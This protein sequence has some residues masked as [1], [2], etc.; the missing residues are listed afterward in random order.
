MN[1]K[2]I[3]SI[4]L[5]TLIL[6]SC[7]NVG[8]GNTTPANT[9]IKTS[10]NKVTMQSASNNATAEDESTFV[11]SV[12]EVNDVLVLSPNKMVYID[13]QSGLRI[14]SGVDA[15]LSESAILDDTKL[16]DFVKQNLGKFVVVTDAKQQP[17]IPDNSYAID[18]D[19]DNHS[20]SW[21]S[22]VD[23]NTWKQYS[24]NV[25]KPSGSVEILQTGKLNVPFQKTRS[26]SFINSDILDNTK[27]ISLNYLTGGLYTNEDGE[28]V[29]GVVHQTYLA[30]TATPI[31]LEMATSGQD[32]ATKSIAENKI[33][34]PLYNSATVPSLY[35]FTGSTK[36]AQQ[37]I[38][39][40]THNIAVIGSNVPAHERSFWDNWGIALA[41]AFFGSVV[42]IIASRNI[43]KN[44]VKEYKAKFIVD[45]NRY[46][47]SVKTTLSAPKIITYNKNEIKTNEQ[48]NE[49][50]N[51]VTNKGT[52]KQISND[53]ISKEV[54]DLIYD[55]DKFN[56]ASFKLDADT[57]LLT[58][59]GAS[60]KE[61]RA[62]ALEERFNQ[63]N[64][65]YKYDCLKN[66]K[67][68]DS[69]RVFKI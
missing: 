17:Y 67:I 1:K 8:G 63:N 13:S 52:S 65:N 20:I 29:D 56:E 4:L 6:N 33:T 23:N 21:V 68:F 37:Y 2:L 62:S 40:N 24:F 69:F 22:F 41:G 11:R 36:N 64:K 46:E 32:N 35:Q 42:G 14:W 12:F 58:I 15:N 47:N 26:I 66:F 7:Y 39:E 5:S 54:Q 3:C 16:R 45:A 55:R 61:I 43:A 9:A 28:T 60:G 49:N 30:K 51:A 48:V 19:D 44:N 50:S 31:I 34:E 38:K 27:L 25:F 57:G 10:K 59:D 53:M 18:Y